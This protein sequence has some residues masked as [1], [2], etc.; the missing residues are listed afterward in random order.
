MFWPRW[1]NPSSA[2]EYQADQFRGLDLSPKPLGPPAHFEPVEAKADA[3]SEAVQVQAPKAA[4]HIGVSK[5]RIA[6]RVF[7]PLVP[8]CTIGI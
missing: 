5:A 3:Q 2:D 8:C 7:S 1:G 6:R 4:P